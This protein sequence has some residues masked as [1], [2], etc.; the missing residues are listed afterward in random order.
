MTTIT[1]GVYMHN[2]LQTDSCDGDNCLSVHAWNLYC[3]SAV[4]VVIYGFTGMGL[5]WIHSLY[6]SL[7]SSFLFFF[8][9]ALPCFSFFYTVINGFYSI[10]TAVVM[11]CLFSITAPYGIFALSPLLLFVIGF[12]AAYYDE[13]IRRI[14][15][16]ITFYPDEVIRHLSK[17]FA[18]SEEGSNFSKP[19]IVASSTNS[20][21]YNTD[22]IINNSM[23][24]EEDNVM[25]TSTYGLLNIVASP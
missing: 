8:F 4:R 10:T 2:I 6:V 16:Y 23:N 11:I 5:M 12:G 15:F 1:T 21:I 17:I 24:S 22:N 9:P 20:N 3:G 13:R 18:V 14:D 19:S 25:N 7:L